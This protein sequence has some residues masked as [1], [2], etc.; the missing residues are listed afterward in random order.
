MGSGRRRE[1][2]H[3]LFILMCN[4]WVFALLSLSE[5]LLLD[6]REFV[7]RSPQNKKY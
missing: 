1:Y 3:L 4:D 7:D 6:V 5:I 2:D